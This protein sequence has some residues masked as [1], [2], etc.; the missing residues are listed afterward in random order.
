MRNPFRTPPSQST[1]IT[2]NGK[3]TVV[4]GNNVT[5]KN[6]VVQVDGVTVQTGLQGD[7]KIL[8]EG[9]LASVESDCSIECGEVHGDV[10]GGNSVKCGNVQGN[11]WAGNSVNRR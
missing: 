5:I 6:G 9:P 4:Q 2:V 11:V 1:R 8:W 7:V 3:T 10:E